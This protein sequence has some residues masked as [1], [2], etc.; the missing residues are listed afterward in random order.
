MGC[1]R[2]AWVL[3]FEK[4]VEKKKEKKSH[5]VALPPI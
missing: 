1:G 5:N 4:E 3:C 2:F